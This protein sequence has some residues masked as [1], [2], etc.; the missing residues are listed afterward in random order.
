MKAEWIDI[1]KLEEILTQI[2][3]GTPWFYVL[4]AYM[5][6]VLRRNNGNRTHTSSDIK[7]PI[8][9]LR[10]KLNAVEVLGFEIPEYRPKNKDAA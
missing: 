3:K 4:Y 8:R 5:T 10:Y 9:T 6:S 2:P 7:M 1:E